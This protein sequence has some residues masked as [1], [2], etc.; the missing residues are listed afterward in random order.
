M[1]ITI[2]L[3][4]APP[5][6]INIPLVLLVKYSMGA[7]LNPDAI[8]IPI[9]VEI[10]AAN[11]MAG[12]IGTQLPKTFSIIHKVIDDTIPGNVPKVK[13]AIITGIS[14]TSNFKYGITGNG[15]LRGRAVNIAERAAKAAE[16]EILKVL[17]SMRLGFFIT[18]YSILSLYSIL[19]YKIFQ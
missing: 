15:I 5:M 18:F 19:I 17:F 8:H 6:N 13:K 1:P 10:I 7:F 9:I 14:A 12:P 2:T 3:S 4:V 16:I 11:F